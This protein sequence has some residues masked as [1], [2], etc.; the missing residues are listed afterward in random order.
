MATTP[1]I[2]DEQGLAF[3]RA[4]IASIHLSPIATILTDPRLPDNAII[5]VN[6]A[7]C[8]LTGYEAHE[9]IGRNCRFLAG[10]AGESPGRMAL[11]QAVA[12]ARPVLVEVRNVKKDGTPFRNAVMIAPVLLPNVDVGYFLG[13]QMDVGSARVPAQTVDDATRKVRAL[14]RR[15]RDVLLGMLAGKLN[16]QI[17]ADLGIDE[18]T[19]K[20]H[21]AALLKRLGV[22]TTADAIR[23]GIEAGMSGLP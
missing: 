22:R 15:Q 10:D 6:R 14:T 3:E 23:L 16:K 18:K 17:G 19:V 13:S 1:S 5:A 11:R 8:A 21:R 12:E 20:M 7:F 4:L 9:V 2:A